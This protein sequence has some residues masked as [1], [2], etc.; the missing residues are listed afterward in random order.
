MESAAGAPEAA[1]FA[2]MTGP[3]PGLNLTA[4][5]TSSPM[6]LPIKIEIKR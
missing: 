1:V 3:A 4:D 2:A 6:S 5:L